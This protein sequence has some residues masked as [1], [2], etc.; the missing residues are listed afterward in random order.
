MGFRERLMEKIWSRERDLRTK[1]WVFGCVALVSCG[2]SSFYSYNFL[3]RFFLTALLRNVPKKR[4]A[5]VQEGEYVK[6]V[7]E[8]TT[9]HPHEAG[10][11]AA[12][13]AATAKTVPVSATTQEEPGALKTPIAGVAC[14]LLHALEYRVV[15]EMDRASGRFH[16]G[17]T[18]GKSNDRDTTGGGLEYTK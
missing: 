5:D 13:E 10:A 6:V 9:V 18:K 4:L 16:R 3:K 15:E 14:V 12:G 1:A 8:I 17:K 11:G 7:G 2:V